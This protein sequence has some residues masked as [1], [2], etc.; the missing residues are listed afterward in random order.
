M[1]RGPWVALVKEPLFQP[2]GDGDGVK[3]KD[4]LQVIRGFRSQPDVQ[5]IEVPFQQFGRFLNPDPGDVI[6]GFELFHV[7]QPGKQDFASVGEG[8]A[9]LPLADHSPTVGVVLGDL[10]PQLGKAALPEGPGYLAAYQK[11]VARL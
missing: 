6:D 10:A 7:V 11:A 2:V 3:G 5:L 9:H 4:D 8:N 1:H